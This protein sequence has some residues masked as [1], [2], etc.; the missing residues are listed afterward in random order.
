M[1]AD[2]LV[3]QRLEAGEEER[4][5]SGEMRDGQ[6]QMGDGHVGSVGSNR[7]QANVLRKKKARRKRLVKNIKI[8]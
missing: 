5:G 2:K 3:S 1:S 6:G 4:G 7:V 8:G